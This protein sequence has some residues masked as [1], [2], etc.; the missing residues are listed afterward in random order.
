MSPQGIGSSSFM[1]RTGTQRVSLS[2]VEL[3]SSKI[4]RSRDQVSLSVSLTGCFMQS[5]LPFLISRCSLLDF[6]IEGL[7]VCSQAK[8]DAA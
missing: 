6:S 7:Q 8:F 1:M 4:S 2:K 5:C 3:A